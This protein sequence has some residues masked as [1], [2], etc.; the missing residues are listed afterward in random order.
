[1][2]SPW[3]K[4]VAKLTPYFV[5]KG[6]NISLCKEIVANWILHVKDTDFQKVNVCLQLSSIPCKRYK[7]T[8]AL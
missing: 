4:S 3:L 8:E 6:S 1:M 7:F 5:R 2:H